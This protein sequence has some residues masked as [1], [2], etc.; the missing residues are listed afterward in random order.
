M[1]NTVKDGKIEKES[2]F[3]S[4]KTI[5]ELS[6]VKNFKKEKINVT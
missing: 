4:T 1:C 2:Q 3:T 6:E 5:K